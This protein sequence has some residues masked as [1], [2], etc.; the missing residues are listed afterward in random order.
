MFQ[1]STSL[2]ESHLDLTCT[3]HGGGASSVTADDSSILRPSRWDQ[4]LTIQ[5]EFK[6]LTNK[7]Y[8]RFTKVS[9]ALFSRVTIFRPGI[10]GEV[11]VGALCVI[12]DSDPALASS[13]YM[14]SQGTA[15][16]VY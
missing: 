2:L 1:H 13:G 15:W 9:T 11:P 5:I 7:T 8:G 6:D 10:E 12:E 4:T 14:P 3:C 16:Q